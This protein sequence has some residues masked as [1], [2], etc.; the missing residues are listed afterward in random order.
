VYPNAKNMHR[1]NEN[2][3]RKYSPHL[4]ALTIAP[5]MAISEPASLQGWLKVHLP[6]PRATLGCA[7]HADEKIAHKVGWNKFMVHLSSTGLALFWPGELE[8]HSAAMHLPLPALASWQPEQVTQ[9]V[10]QKEKSQ[11]RFKINSKRG[12]LLLHCE[13]PNAAAQQQWLEC[14]RASIET[15]V[16]GR[17]STPVLQHYSRDESAT[18]TAQQT[19][20]QHI[21]IAPSLP[22]HGCMGQGSGQGRSDIIAWATGEALTPR[23][24]AAAPAG[25]TSSRATPWKSLPTPILMLV[26]HAWAALQT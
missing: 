2:T 24:A 11:R 5:S 1:I 17:R 14:A 4:Q 9:D 8:A 21:E 16:A 23:V 7:V 26:V 19:L 22:S 13:A 18:S 15:L 3:S 25:S 20:Q 12:I 10:K 6:L